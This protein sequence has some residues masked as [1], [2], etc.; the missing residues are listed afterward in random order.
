MKMHQKLQ[1]DKA[2]RAKKSTFAAPRVLLR[3][4]DVFSRESAFG[5]SPTKRAVSTA[6]TTGGD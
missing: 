5:E 2:F 4:M 3:Y 6:R 1:K